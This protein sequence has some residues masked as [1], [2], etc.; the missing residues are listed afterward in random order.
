MHGWNGLP[1]YK[2]FNV[3]SSVHSYSLVLNLNQ[4]VVRLMREKRYPAAF[5]CYYNFHKVDAISSDNLFYKMVIH[6]HSDSTFRR[7][8]KE[9]R[10]TFNLICFRNSLSLF[11]S[12]HYTFLWQLE[13]QNVWHF[14][15]HKPGLWPLY[16]GTYFF[17]FH[18]SN[19]LFIYCWNL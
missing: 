4:E 6:V 5:K 13:L 7:Y 8:Q 15:R 18:F 3:F 10:S 19:V 9:M 2:C 12:L 1:I 14:F 17:L 16:R 11:I